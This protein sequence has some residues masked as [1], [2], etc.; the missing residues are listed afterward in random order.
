[1]ARQRENV[2]MGLVTSE[3]P[4]DLKAGELQVCNNLIYLPSRSSLSPAPSRLYNASSTDLGGTISGLRFCSFDFV[5][6]LAELVSGSTTLTAVS[7]YT[8]V[9]VTTGAR[10]YGDGIALG[11]TYT[12]VNSTSGTLSAAA[13]RTG[14]F[15]VFLEANNYLVAQIAGSYQI[16]TLPPSSTVLTFS[17]LATITA[18]DTLE[19]VQYSNEHFLLNGKNSNLVFKSNQSTRQ[20]GMQPVI[21]SPLVTVTT[22]GGTWTL[23]TGVGF[24]SYWTTEVDKSSIIRKTDGTI[25]GEGIESTFE[26]IP[27]IANVVSTA[28]FVTVRRPPRVNATAT[29]WRLWRSFKMTATTAAAAAKED[30]FPDGYLVG[31]AQMK[32]DGTQE[33]IIDGQTT[34]SSAADRLVTTIE[35]N[36]NTNG[37]TPIWVNPNNIFTNDGTFTTLDTSTLTATQAVYLRMGGMGFTVSTISPPIVGIVIKVK[38]K[39]S[40]NTNFPTFITVRPVITSASGAIIGNPSPKTITLTT[41]NTEYILPSVNGAEITSDLWGFSNLNPADF[42]DGKFSVEIRV[43]GSIFPGTLSLDYVR[44]TLYYNQGT[45]TGTLDLFPKITVAPFGIEASVGRNGPPPVSS[46]GDVFQDSLV[47]NDVTDASMVRYSFPTLM[48]YFPRVY[49][50]NFETKEQDKVTNIKTVG[51]VLVIGL[52]RQI[53]RVNYL[54]RE[55]DAEFDRGRAVELIETNHG[56]MGTQAATLVTLPGQPQQL[57]YVS[58]YGLHITDGYRTKLLSG[59]LNWGALGINPISSVILSNN[60]EAYSLELAYGIGGSANTQV[61]YFSYHPQHVKESGLKVSGPVDYAVYS[62]TIGYPA[63]GSGDFGITKVYS[64]SASNRVEEEQLFANTYQ[65][66]VVNGTLTEGGATRALLAPTFTTRRMRL[67]G[68]GREWEAKEFYLAYSKS[69]GEVFTVTPTL[70]RVGQVPITVA[71]QTITTSI[72]TGADNIG[73]VTFANL[74]DGI[75]YKVDVNVNISPESSLG[76][77]YLVIEGESFQDEES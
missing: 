20:H 70:F 55:T 61:L 19:S 51:N 7:G 3:I 30:I 72:F 33:T 5:P 41:T 38:G 62:Q 26:G 6:V 13:T 36:S 22:S 48:D 39:T 47:L 31:E 53:Y 45:Q 16:A 14:Q 67:A 32:D 57:A 4:D 8:I 76:I 28:Y 25:I 77:D 58:Q 42:A 15:L 59:D 27:A 65:G 63:R 29:H 11:T 49:F 56:I 23:D 34:A 10:I 2:D 54:P 71:A 17:S 52:R 50:L 21:T 1:M 64:G 43:G 73:K 40:T 35:T 24:Y 69:G 12:V 75:E 44:A 9:G 60:P 68:F 66:G 37:S 74:A 46:T 18:G